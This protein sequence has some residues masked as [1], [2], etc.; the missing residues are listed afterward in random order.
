M[1][2]WWAEFL[3]FQTLVGYCFVVANACIGFY[4]IKDLNRMKGDL[5]FVKWHKRIGWIE[6]AFFYIIAIQCWIMVFMNWIMIDVF[7]R[8]DNGSGIHFIIGGITAT[9]LFTFKF[10]VARHFKDTI[11]RKGAIIG[12]IGFYSCS[13]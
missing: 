5:V 13:I 7:T 2:Q 4:N 11:Y 6:T 1:G 10:T 9:I 8:L 3:V 12:P